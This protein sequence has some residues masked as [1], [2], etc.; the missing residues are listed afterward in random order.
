MTKTLPA[1][2]FAQVPKVELHLHLEG[3]IPHDALWKLVQK[4]GSESSVPNLQALREKFNYRDFPHFLET[5]GWKNRFIQEY[6][7]LKFIAEAVARD[8]AGQNIRYAEV[9]YT[10]MD[11]SRYGLHTQKITE[12]I[13]SGLRLVPEIKIMLITDFCRDYGPDAATKTLSEIN[14][15]KDLGVIGVTIGGSE[16]KYP[17]EPYAEVYEKARKLGFHTSAHAGEAAGSES[18]WGA[19]RS[20]KVERIGHGTRAFEDASLVAYLAKHK[21]PLEVCPISNVKTGVV[22]SIKKHPVR[23]YYD[24]GM[25][26]TINTDDPKMF[27]NSLAEEY[28]TLYTELGFSC[29]EIQDLILNGVRASWLAEDAKKE[30]VKSLRNDPGWQIKTE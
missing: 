16:Q 29:E 14:E 11:F 9:F 21:I 19:I 18:I 28:Q 17:P 1:A 20:L 13:R 27:G 7:D 15:V 2:W 23:Q 25:M 10:P 26:V 4:Y 30:L 3:A 8:L 12:A 22:A 5:W 24:A 6:E